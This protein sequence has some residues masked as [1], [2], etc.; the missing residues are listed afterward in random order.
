MSPS[1]HPDL[2]SDL[3][4]L[5][6]EEARSPDA[7]AAL[8]KVNAEMFVAAPA[9]DRDSIDT[10]ETLVLGFL[11]RAD[12]ATL[13]E[14]AR[15]L[16]PCADTPPAV[17]DFLVRHSPETQALVLRHA[18]QLPR[19]LD[20]RLLATPDGRVRLA[21]RPDLDAATVWRLLV[22]H[23][24]AVEDVLA[25][26]PA[27]A[28]ADP[29]FR[30]LVARADRRP[31]LARLLLRRSD[32]ATGDEARLYLAAD[33]ER[34]RR[35]RE[36]VAAVLTPASAALPMGLTEHD[37]GLFLAAGRRGDGPGLETLLSAAFGLPAATEWRALAIGRHA[38]LALALKALG[39][40]EKEATRIFL[41]LH[42][43]LS[44][45][46]SALKDLVREMRDVPGP[47]ALALVEAIL[48][49]KLPR[50]GPRGL[51]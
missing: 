8:L 17:L 26:N 11:P 18:P 14:I 33:S 34:R 10:F 19:G 4:G 5:G 7:R 16:A 23:E 25:A 30:E 22:L 32:L 45:P 13:V 21:S 3:S 49:V 12:D 29:G 1:A 27:L 50:S 15:I 46:L 6:L 38:L 42:P 43:A 9:H 47:V 28:P 20:T 39:L 35:I 44:S 41:T 2:W 36:R 37:V 40:S 51:A 48:D 31:A 24:S